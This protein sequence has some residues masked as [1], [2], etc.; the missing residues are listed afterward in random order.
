MPK[1]R[2]IVLSGKCHSLLTK[3]LREIARTVNDLDLELQNLVECPQPAFV[4]IASGAKKA[5]RKK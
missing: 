2:D 4:L 3:R 1:Q 5:A